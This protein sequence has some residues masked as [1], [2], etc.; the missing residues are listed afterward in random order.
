MNL[1]FQS[2]KHGGSAK[3]FN[4]NVS[5]K[6]QIIMWFFPNNYDKTINRLHEQL[7]CLLII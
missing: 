3:C 2:N 1:N 7:L 4:D 5:E 6:I